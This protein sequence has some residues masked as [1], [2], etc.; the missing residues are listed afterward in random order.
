MRTR[1]RRRPATVAW[2]A[3]CA[4]ALAGAACGQAAAPSASRSV[5]S[6][7]SGSGS[8]AAVPATSGATSTAPLSWSQLGNGTQLWVEPNAPGLASAPGVFAMC[9]TGSVQVSRDAGGTWS[10][11][12]TAG[13]PAALAKTAYAITTAPGAQPPTPACTEALADPAHAGSVYAVFAVGTAQ[14]GMPPVFYAALD[15][16]NNGGTWTALPP[17]AGSDPGGFGGLTVAANGAVQAM[18]GPVLGAP[19]ATTPAFAVIQ[20]SDGGST[21][22]PATLACP[23]S[24][25]CLRWGPAPSGT[26]SCAMHDYPQPI[27]RSADG[28]QTWSSAYDPTVADLANGCELGELVGLS[29]SRAALITR[30]AGTSLPSVQ[31]TDDGGQTWS[32][33]ALPALPG[34][35]TPAPKGVQLLPSG[36]LVA[37]LGAGTQSLDLLLPTAAAWCSVPGVTLSGVATSAGSLQ[38]V[39]SNLY[40]EQQEQQ[41]SPTLQSVPLSAV[42]C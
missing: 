42:H 33:V 6:S 34:G 40:W 15:T 26:G 37:V 23:A 27:E 4:A 9:A 12:S 14:Y 30:G 22:E 11:V 1:P 39:G 5:V 35:V 13:V 29:T 7:A 17:P 19:A 25:P 18:Y 36:A 21:W 3:I 10:T 16:T 2:A 20:T 38:P 8:S 24:G 41:G 31:V 32:P 28:G